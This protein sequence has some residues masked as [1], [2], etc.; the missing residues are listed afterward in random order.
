VSQAFE[1]LVLCYHAVSA[2]WPHGLSVAPDAFER[3]LQLLLNRGYRPATAEQTLAGRGKLLHVTFDDAYRS[4]ANG[5]PILE[6]LG[7]PATVFVCSGYADDGRPLDIPELAAHARERP[8]ELATMDWDAVR[9]LVERG[10]EIGSHTVTHPH[11]PRLGDADLARELGESRERLEDELRRPCPLLAYP[12]GQ[13]DLRVRAAAR[14]AGYKA[15][16]A[17]PSHRGAP[18]PFA[19]PRVAIWRK[20]TLVRVRVKTSP[21]VRRLAR[22][23]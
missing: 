15:A 18:D 4:I 17:M 22:A 1:P 5:L 20:D 7:V 8:A 3:Q 16:F 9:E 21:L 14:A 19:L 6:R 12:Y 10:V 23:F 11:L 13:E 2:T